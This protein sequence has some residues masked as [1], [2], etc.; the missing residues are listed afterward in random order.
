MCSCFERMWYLWCPDRTLCLTHWGWLH[1]FNIIPSS[2]WFWWQ[3]CQGD[4]YEDLV[5]SWDWKLMFH[6]GE[7]FLWILSLLYIS[8][9][10]QRTGQRPLIM[11][12]K[13]TSAVTSFR[14]FHHLY[15]QWLNSD[16]KVMAV[17]YSSWPLHSLNILP[18]VF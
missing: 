13:V 12:G 5:Q 11:L 18:S 10:L 4:N 9:S 6:Q 8:Q 1:F 14:P 2:D 3:Q 17:T 16:S 15:R 7:G